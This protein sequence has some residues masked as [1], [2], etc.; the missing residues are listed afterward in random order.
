MAQ[1]RP[2]IV[3]FGSGAFGVPTLERIVGRYEV[4]LVVSQPDRP[5]GRGKTLTP[6]PVAA[7]AVEL[8]LEVVKPEDVNAPEV[9]ARIRGLGAS[10]WVVIAFGQKLSKELLDGV[11]AINLH[12]SLLPAYRGAAPIQR[13]V[14]DGCAVTGVSV[15]SLAE[16]MDAGLVYATRSRAVGAE[17]TS[18]EVHDALARLGVEAVEEVLAAHAAGAARGVAQDESR[19]TRARKLAKHE[20]TIDLAARPAAA[21]RAW[22]NGLNSWPGCTVLVGGVP[23][24]LLRV[25]EVSAEGLGAPGAL[26][27]DGRVRCADGAVELLAVQP[28]GGKPMEVAALLRG[29]PALV[30][31]RVEPLAAPAAG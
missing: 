4:A 31:A 28:L 11:F 12:G 21:A 8:G 6:T 23:L 30:G 19:A 15:I 5:A 2:R 27:G 1:A 7:R 26:H 25:R 13:A 14:M 22:I 10:A 29:R 9:V 18:D 3:F 17:E 16:R 20:G 24:K